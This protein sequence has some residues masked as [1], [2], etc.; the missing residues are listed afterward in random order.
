MLYP[1]NISSAPSPVSTA[2]TFLEA[3]SDNRYFATTW[4]LAAICSLFLALPVLSVS[5]PATPV[6]L[7]VLALTCV[8][9]ASVLVAV[10]LLYRPRFE[11]AHAVAWLDIVP[12]L[13]RER[14]SPLIAAFLAGLAK[15]SS[16]TGDPRTRQSSLAAAINT[17]AQWA[18][19]GLIAR[20]LETDN[21]RLRTA[22]EDA[23]GRIGG[24]VAEQAEQAMAS[25]HLA[26]DRIAA[27][28]LVAGSNYDDLGRL[29]EKLPA[30]RRWC[31]A[32]WS[33][34]HRP[35]RPRSGSVIPRAG[36]VPLPRGTNPVA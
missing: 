22:A 20:D 33:S 17:L 25:R 2:L 28:N 11:S 6:F 32:R 9:T 30:P 5:W 24:P 18:S 1:A 36:T 4:L 10:H 34:S 7:L 35:L 12:A 26:S 27:A 15:A 13:L 8:F 29:F 3:A 21:Q 14:P 19:K 31:T 23:L 16:K